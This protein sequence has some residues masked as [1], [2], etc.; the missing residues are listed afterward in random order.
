LAGGFAVVAAR[1]ACVVSGAVTLLGP[2]GLIILTSDHIS[3]KPVC[4]LTKYAALLG[5]QFAANAITYSG[6]RNPRIVTLGSLHQQVGD[7]QGQSADTVGNV[8]YVA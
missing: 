5:R 3:A 8:H 2:I 4:F 1:W 7:Q 6:H